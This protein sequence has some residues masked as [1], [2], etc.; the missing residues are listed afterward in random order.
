MQEY[1]L[2]SWAAWAVILIIQNFSFTYVSRA[3]NSGSL[4]R[5]L[6]AAIVSNGVWFVG[7]AIVFSKL[8]DYMTGK[9][10]L[11]MAIAT[12]IFYTIFTVAGSLIAHYWS[13]RTEKGRA[14][15]GANKKYAQVTVE[16]W[17]EVKEVLKQW[18]SI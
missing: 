13:L 3:R 12:G 16:E 6:R 7:A 11:A 4:G 14:A 10:G 9:F 2:W 1:E 18:R 17:Q 8:Y 15:V 5:H